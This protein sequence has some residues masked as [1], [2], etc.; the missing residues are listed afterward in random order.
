MSEPHHLARFI[1][2]AENTFDPNEE[3]YRRCPFGTRTAPFSIQDLFSD[4][5]WEKDLLKGL[6]VN[7]SKFSVPQDALWSPVSEIIYEQRCEYQQKNGIVYKSAAY[8][9]PVRDPKTGVTLIL[10]HSPINCNIA[11]CDINVVGLEEKTSK[12]MRR[13]IKA[14]LATFF[15]EI[16]PH[17]M[18]KKIE[19]NDIATKVG[20]DN[21]FLLKTVNFDSFVFVV[22]LLAIVIAAVLLELF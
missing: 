8:L 14:F 9:Y 11:H 20:G 22:L 17:E 13:E 6:S 5:Q 16:P 4:I 19:V 12:P 7:R 2:I 15:N 1:T 18:Q 21:K 10:S 3:I